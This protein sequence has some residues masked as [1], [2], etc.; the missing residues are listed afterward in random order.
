MSASMDHLGFLERGFA[1]YFAP[2]PP[3]G[4]PP[5][6]VLPQPSALQT[7]KLTL[8]VVRM[9]IVS[10][11]WACSWRSCSLPTV[12][13]ALCLSKLL[14]FEAAVSY[15]SPD[16][17][18]EMAEV[19]FKLTQVSPSTERNYSCTLSRMIRLPEWGGRNRERFLLDSLIVKSI[20]GC[21][22]LPT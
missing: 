7:T 1:C 12:F 11:G 8:P 10:S 14:L 20:S 3:Q 5:Q 21:Y 16:A 19:T 17:E 22:R 15:N 9:Q 6:N 13:Q 2:R 18:T 4:P